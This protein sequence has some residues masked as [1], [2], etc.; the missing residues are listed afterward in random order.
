MFWKLGW[1]VKSLSYL[2]EKDIRETIYQNETFLKYRWNPFQRLIFWGSKNV[3]WVSLFIPVLAFSSA[4]L[5][6]QNYDFLKFFL[7]ATASKGGLSSLI[8]SQSIILGVQATILGLIFPLVIAFIGIL[9]QGKSSHEAMWQIYKQT[10]GFLL[11]G[12]SAL[13]LILYILVISSIS[14]WENHAAKV[15]YS[16]GIITWFGLNIVLIAWFLWVTI[17]FISPKNRM[18]MI[19][20]YAMNDVIVSDVRNR[21]KQNIS[22]AA[23]LEHFKLLPPSVEGSYD[24][25][26][27]V[28]NKG[29]TPLHYFSTKPVYLKNVYYRFLWLGVIVWIYQAKWLSKNKGD[30][31]FLALPI[32]YG[33]YLSNKHKLAETN[34]SSIN[35]ISSFFIKNSVRFSRNEPSIDLDLT[36]LVEVL[37]GQVED[38]LKEGNSR[39]FEAAFDDLKKLVRE[40][41]SSMSFVND[42]QKNDNWLLLSDGRILFGRNLLDVLGREL[43]R[44]SE[45]VSKNISND[46]SYFEKI[47]YFYPHL[48]S[49]QQEKRPL[50]VGLD[51]IDGHYYIW[52]NLMGWSSTGLKTGV[53]NQNADRA[54]KHF[55]G[56]WEYWH[57]FIGGVSITKN[58]DNFEY[59]IQ[60]LKSTSC[61]VIQALKYENYEG[62][63]WAADMLVYWYELFSNN[64][65]QSASYGWHYQVLT[66]GLIDEDIDERLKKAIFNQDDR[67]EYERE[68]KLICLRNVWEEVRLITYAYIMQLPSFKSNQKVRELATALFQA[69]RLESTN[70]MD[71]P[72]P[73]IN[74]PSDLLGV[75]LRMQ[76]LLESKNYFDSWQEKHIERLSSIQQPLWVSGRSYFSVGTKYDLYLPFFYRMMGVGLTNN[77]F[78][79]DQS[80]MEFLKAGVEHNVLNHAISCLESLTT[81]DDE[82][83]D[84]ICYQFNCDMDAAK[85]K[86]DCFVD[87]IKAVIKEL[88]R[89][90]NQQVIDS[91]IDDERLEALGIAATGL[92]FNIQKGP[93]PISLFDDVCNLEVI[94][95]SK[96]YEIQ[97]LDYRKS[98]ISKLPDDSV[99]INEFEWLERVVKGKVVA[100]VYSQLFKKVSWQEDS[101][102]DLKLLINEVVK[103]GKELLREGKAPMFFVGTWDLYRLID[104]SKW[105]YDPDDEKLPFNIE[106]RDSSDD[107]YVCHLEGIEVHRLPFDKIE[108]SVLLTKEAFEKI[109]ILNYGDGRYV[110]A[111]YKPNEG[112]D[113]IKG[114]LVLEYGIECKFNLQ[115]GFKYISSNNE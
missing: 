14:P 82:I 3:I 19:V 52:R 10:S 107:S 102:T 100:N 27:F 86:R 50:K 97:I 2:A 79:L 69:K 113:S 4:L 46:V 61:M 55:V 42:Y 30:E 16:A 98:H 73:K 62:A 57:H 81:I 91:A 56:S 54:L 24:I 70:D 37:F 75:F 21:L 58:Q 36:S 90:A 7:P 29:L 83:L 5:I 63:R 11:V 23:Q 87:S 34:L 41:E 51:Y 115:N 33:E 45:N 88:R 110:K 92:A 53:T 20:S 12:F 94:E 111:S 1:L 67:H 114:T 26:S 32:Y 8:E 76:N 59:S 104:S 108:Y 22:R 78:T 96:L 85:Q 84:H 65:H 60:H 93:I 49:F 112:P 13:T 25:S 18:E 35:P 99:P 66:P 28:I 106:T 39:Q 103:Q 64:F 47:C 77:S 31:P 17:R 48:F 38:A 43:Y 71:M 72:V 15:S 6:F 101:F 68:E 44:L 89:G 80:W 9:I 74:S 40:L 105:Q 109:N 95:N